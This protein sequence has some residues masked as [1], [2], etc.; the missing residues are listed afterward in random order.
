METGDSYIHKKSGKEYVV[1]DTGYMKYGQRDTPC[2][3]Y[4]SMA[5]WTMYARSTV[6]F[7]LKFEKK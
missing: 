5:T 3:F 2:V 6:N 4:R 7:T 1:I